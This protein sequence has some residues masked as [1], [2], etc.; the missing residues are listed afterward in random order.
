MSLL[1]VDVADLV[2]IIRMTRSEK[3]NA[4]S[5]KLMAELEEALSKYCGEYGVVLTGSG[6]VFS[7]GLDLAEIGSVGN[8]E[9]ARAY[10]GRVR[11][12]VFSMINCESP[13]IIFMNG[14]AYGMGMELLYLADYVVSIRDAELSIPGVRYGMVPPLT[15]TLMGTLGILKVR[16]LLGVNRRLSVEE[17][18]S[19]GLVND[20]VDSLDEGIEVSV[21]AARELMGIPK[22]TRSVIKQY[23]RSTLLDFVHRF[24]AVLEDMARLSLDAE[25]KDRLTQFMRR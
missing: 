20:V 8:I 7:A 21:R 23:I 14:S 13:L 17:A 15:L 24:E 1:S 19:W 11:G 12:L 22:A 2:V 4:L 18:K 10:F 25:V 9:E 16:E 3:R 6:R 5:S